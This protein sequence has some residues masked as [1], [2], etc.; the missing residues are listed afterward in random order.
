MNNICGDD[1]PVIPEID[2]PTNVTRSVIPSKSANGPG[3]IS[4]LWLKTDGNDT[5]SEESYIAKSHLVND[6]RKNGFIIDTG[7]KDYCIP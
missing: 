6:L 2:A 5:S 3:L 4:R 7:C 1:S